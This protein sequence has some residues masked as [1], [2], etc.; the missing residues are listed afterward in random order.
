V[1][2][3]C[4]DHEVT[5]PLAY[6]RVARPALYRPADPAGCLAST[7]HL[8]RTPGRLPTDQ[9][10]EDKV[11]YNVMSD[12][13]GCDLGTQGMSHDNEHLFKAKRGSP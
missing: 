11:D 13:A 9:P 10:R 7:A 4:A 6:L 12:N 1:R 5:E 2:G 8:A 3:L